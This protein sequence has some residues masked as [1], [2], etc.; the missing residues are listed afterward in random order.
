MSK[1]SSTFDWMQF[2]EGRAR[3][4]GGFRCWDEMGRDTFALELRG[5]EYFGQIDNVF[6][7]NDSDYNISIGAFGYGRGEDVGMPEI[8]ST[9]ESGVG[10]REIFTPT[11]ELAARALVI[12][13]I[14]AGLKYEFPPSPLR[15]TETSHFMG[16]II[17][18]EGWMLVRSNDVGSVS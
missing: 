6:L 17:F 2:P 18:Q 14:H 1:Y 9:D 16:K 7:D 8:G 13:L 12:Q 3:F 4:T 11:E 10:V 15:Q 5:N